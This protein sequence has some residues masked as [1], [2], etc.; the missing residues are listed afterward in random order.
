MEKIKLTT[1]T[2]A[3]A[4]MLEVEAY[5]CYECGIP[6][7]DDLLSKI[8][9]KNCVQDYYLNK[10]KLDKASPIIFMI[11]SAP[12]PQAR[13]RM[14]WR[15]GRPPFAY[16]PTKEDKV[17]FLIQAKPYAP[18]KPLE[19]P[20]Y[21]KV[22]LRLPRPKK[23]FRTGKFSNDLRED[24]PKWHTKRGDWDNYGKFISDALN[25][26]FWKDDSQISMVEIQKVYHQ[27]TGYIIHIMEL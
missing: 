6:F 25:G 2:I 19:G 18:K 10:T 22:I 27:N 9:C 1:P 14:T 8:F 21:L 23:H 20:V 3:P 26:V 4:D 7:I 5:E 11:H 24:A 17:N 12:V 16:D 15:K 13:H